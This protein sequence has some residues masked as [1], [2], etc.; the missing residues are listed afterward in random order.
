MST[1]SYTYNAHVG[2]CAGVIKMMLCDAG[3]KPVVFA[4]THRFQGILFLGGSVSV[5]M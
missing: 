1:K 5:Y 4:S 3:Y 2:V